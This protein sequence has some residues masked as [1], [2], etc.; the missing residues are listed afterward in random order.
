MATFAE[1]G[2]VS[3]VGDSSL[4][5]IQS[6]YIR[7]ATCSATGNVQCKPYET[8]NAGGEIRSGYRC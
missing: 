1:I 2:G 8:E 3:K 7:Q 4:Q 5:R 6:R